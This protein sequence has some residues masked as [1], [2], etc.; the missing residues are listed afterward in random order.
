MRWF[1]LV[2]LLAGSLRADTYFL[3]VSGLGGEP[4]YEQRFSGW[5]KDLDKIVKAEPNA[6]VDTLI[7]PDATKAKMEAKLRAIATESKAGDSLVLMLIGHGSFDESNYKFNIPG[8]DIS[9]TDLAALLDKIPAQ[10]L[11]VD[12]TSSSGG[13]LALLQNQKVK[14]VIITAT[15]SGTEKNATR[16]TSGSRCGRPETRRRAPIVSK[17]AFCEL[18]IRNCYGCYGGDPYPPLGLTEPV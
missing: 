16:S 11:I 18:T 5:A 17:G 14:R 15:K 4:E 13:A 12:M 3:I 8:P 7:G 10:Q 2:S 9:A 1:V 6:K